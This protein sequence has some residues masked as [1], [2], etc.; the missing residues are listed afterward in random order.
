MTQY[1]YLAILVALA[2][3]M[4]W[5]IIYTLIPPVRR[6]VHRQAHENIHTTWMQVYVHLHEGFR[7]LVHAGGWALITLFILGRVA[8]SAIETHKNVGKIID[9]DILSK[10]A[11][12][13]Q[14]SIEDMIALSAAFSLPFAIWSMCS[15]LHTWRQW[16][17]HAHHSD[18]Q[19]RD[20]Q[21]VS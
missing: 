12:L 10:L 6:W 8:Q 5:V 19:L 3:G 16:I 11:H 2:I 14:L 4:L 20:P 17:K 1:L 7:T 9:G 21:I 13:S 15:A 18:T